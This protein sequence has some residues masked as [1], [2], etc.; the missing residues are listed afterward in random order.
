MK[1]EKITENKIRILL[2][3]ED[4]KD[5]NID[6]HTIMTK[7]VESQSFFLDVLDKAEKQFGF[8]TDGC[9][10]LIEGYSSSEND[11]IFTITKYL[12]ETINV[13]PQTFEPRR[14]VVPRRKN[15]SKVKSTVWSFGD[16]DTFCELC[17]CLNHSSISAR[18]L[19]RS[20]SLHKYNGTY[21]LVINE[22]ND[23]V[24][25]KT[26]LSI[27]SEFGRYENVSSNFKY[28]LLEH[29]TTIIKHN[30]LNTGIKYFA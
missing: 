29:G 27:F 9:R 23:K 11:L 5:K 26:L 30:A 17:S 28:K 3:N 25:S 19:A 12:D 20:I 13:T 8:N 14:K 22:I 16:F 7:A 24:C 2:K 10:L 1:I 15:I 18:G 4:I 21:Y 6:L